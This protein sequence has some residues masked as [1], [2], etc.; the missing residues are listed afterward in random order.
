MAKVYSIDGIKRGTIGN[1]TYY[2]YN[3]QNLARRRIIYKRDALTD[4][5]LYARGRYCSTLKAYQLLKDSLGHC[6]EKAKESDNDKNRFYSYNCGKVPPISRDFFRNSNMPPVGDF[7]SSHGSLGTLDIGTITDYPMAKQ[8]NEED[9]S[10]S[11]NSLNISSEENV[12][13]S[14]PV[15]TSF[16]GVVI[17]KN[18][19]T[20]VVQNPPV[21]EVAAALLDRYPWIT[22]GD[23][24]K[25]YGYFY[26]GY[27]ANTASD[28]YVKPIIREQ[29]SPAHVYRY[30]CEFVINRS[31]SAS[32]KL[33]DY[34]LTL[35]PDLNPS[36]ANILICFY[37]GGDAYGVAP[38]NLSQM[39]SGIGTYGATI[40]R[41]SNDIYYS[42]T[43]EMYRSGEYA[44][45]YNIM[46]DQQ[47]RDNVLKEWQD[48][49]KKKGKL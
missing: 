13:E 10:V 1:I 31:I 9:S 3:G 18:K 26:L 15:L 4:V 39:T 8:E 48:H 28:K 14:N 6:F 20:S 23:I 34:G 33:Q 7:I 19:L 35:C 49:Y 16:T 47:Y 36:S 40:V 17:G 27:Q 29:S 24:F 21:R 45:V 41:D 42:S 32:A 2:Y 11:I 46:Q 43:C 12:Q 30:N 25:M 5:Q 38:I 37:M 44:K 22:S